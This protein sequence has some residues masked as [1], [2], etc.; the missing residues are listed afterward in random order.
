MSRPRRHWREMPSS[1]FGPGARDWIAVLPLAAIEQHGPHLPLGVDAIIAEALVARC[2]ETLPDTLPVTFL[3]VQEVCK[4]NEHLSFPGTLT[5][6]WDVAI[7][8]W[9]AIGEGV[10][11][12]GVG[13]LVMITSHGGN[14]APMEI[15]ARELRQRE[16]LRVV[17]TSWGRLGRW[18]EIYRYEEPVTDIHAGLS[19]T[20]LM[21][22]LRPDLVDMARAEHFASA[23]TALARRGGKLGYHGAAANLAWMAEDL[24]P[25][26]AVGDAAAARAEDGAAD[27]AAVIEGFERLI[28]DLAEL[29]E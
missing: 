10:A 12:A 2:A 21:L 25:V 9:V 14:A 28:R 7:R 17:T 8:A 6:D 15:A 11:R 3:P 4:S 5:L 27:I 19:E 1:A 29:P 26:G 16:G 13:T 22:A 20:S 24:N 23:Q 18:R